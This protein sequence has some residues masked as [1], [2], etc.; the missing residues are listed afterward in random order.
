MAS[1]TPIPPD[2]LPRDDDD[3]TAGPGAPLSG[4]TSGDDEAPLAPLASDAVRGGDVPDTDVTPRFGPASG[5]ESGDG[6]ARI[7]PINIEDELKSS[8]IDYS[9]SVIVGRALPDVRDGL[10]PVHRRVLYGMSDLGISPGS[11]HKKSARIVGEVLGKY[12]PHGDSSVY[13]TLVRMAQDFSLRYPLV[14]GQ[15]NFG[16]IDGDSAAAMRYTEARMTRLADELLKD[17]GKDTVDFSDNFDGS[18]QEPDVLPAAFPSLLVNGSDGIAVGMATKIAPHNLTEAINGVLAYIDDPEIT[19]DGL[20]EH[21]PAPDFPTGGIIYGVGGVREAYRTG[22]GRVI[23]RAKMHEEE[24]RAGRSALIVSEI[25]YQ[26]NKSQ[27]LEKIAALANEKKLDGI[28]DLRDESDRDGMRIVIELKRDAAPQVVMN[29]LYKLTPLQ[30]TFGVNNVAL[31]HGRPRTLNLREMVHY[32]VEHRI[33]V[34]TRRTQFE[35]RRAEERAHILEGL[36]IA[37]DH[38][39]AVIAIIRHSEDT[40]AARANLMAGVYPE[41]LTAAQRERLGLTGADGAF[42]LSAAQADAILALRLSRL[43]GLERQKIEEEYRDVL[44]EIERLRSILD[45]RGLLMQVIRG[46]LVDVRDKYGDARRSE[47]DPFG[48]DDFLMEDLIEDEQVIVSVTH[49]GLVKRTSLTEYRT[50]SRGGVGSK[51]TGRRDE[52]YVEHLFTCS[53]HDYLLFFTDH[54]RCYWLRVYELPEGAKTAKGRSIRNLIQI[55]QDDRV[56]AVLSVK[57]ADFEDAPFLDSHY[58]LMATRR[59][60]VK[61]TPLEAFSRPRQAGIIAIDV[62]DG[63]ELIAA[64]LTGGE[65]HVLLAC[66]AG[67]AIRFHESDARAMGRNTSGVRGMLLADREHLVSMV[68][69]EGEPREVLAISENGYGKRTTLDDYRVQS[70]GGKGILTL[71]VTP[72]T[73]KLVALH[74]VTEA[75]DLMIVTENGLMIRMEVGEIRT[76]GRNAQGVRLIALRDGDAIADVTPL[77]KD[78]EDDTA[79][80]PAPPD[81]ATDA[82]PA[83]AADD[84]SDAVA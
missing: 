3:A 56:R 61:K 72:K 18:L 48:G 79:D 66:D 6:S 25:P 51:G 45:S 67:R 37:L 69:M 68:V 57:K 82:A 17:I 60:T 20:M 47:I 65:A 16:S 4:T 10:K 53:N 40:D 62:R 78:D 28:S 8:Y 35:L 24:I 77:A 12:H 63:D 36:T 13:D 52:D 21:I 22:R 31:V 84:T 2:D 39:D 15:G 50:Q 1:D 27:L 38:L 33:D 49:A 9:M 41:R 59:G 83:A 55:E 46:E 14:D 34:V 73:G 76:T 30:Q 58:V 43:T 42:S 44:R 32:Y 26:V 80:A 7:L 81:A 23:M 64:A 74:G 70:R 71:N 29:H 75:D 19:V 11:A 5:P 54:G